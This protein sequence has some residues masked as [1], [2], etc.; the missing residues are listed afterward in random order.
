VSNFAFLEPEWPELHNE[1]VHAEQS[2]LADPR[3]SCFYA[4]RTLELTLD[5]LYQADDTLR[6]PYRNDL[7]GKITEPTLVALVGPKIRTKMDIIRRQ[8]NAAV[9]RSTP[10]STDGAVRVVGE[11]FQVMY[12]VARHYARDQANLPAASLAFDAAQ[13]PQP[14]STDVHLKNQAEI[15]TMAGQFARQQA[16]LAAARSKNRDLDAEIVALRAAIKAAKAMNAESAD[17]HDYNEAETRRL[18]IDLLLKEAGWTLEQSEDREFPVTGMPNPS[19]KGNVDYVLWD[20]NGRPLGLVEAKRTIKDARDGQHQAQLYAERLH[21]QFGQRP[22]IFY[23]NGYQTWI[24]DDLNY[25]PREVQGFYTQEELRLAIQRRTSRQALAGLLINDE[26]AGREYQGRAIRRIS[27]AFEQ[28]HRRAALLVMATGAGKTRTTIALVDLLVRANWVKRVLFLADRQALVTQATNAFKKHVPGIPTVNL[29][30]EKDTEARIFVSTYPTMM[31]LINETAD[32]Q[33]R[34]G[35]G[36]FDLVVI[37]E[38]HRSVYQKYR[39]IFEYFDALLLGLTATPKDEVDRNTYRLFNLRAGEPTDSYS[40]DDAVA[41]AWLVP[42]QAV[43][44]PLRFPR[45]GIKY[46]DLSDEEKAAWDELEWPEDDPPPTEVSADEVNKFLFN[47]DTIDK[48]LETLMTHGVRVEAGD[49]LGKTIIFARNNTHA[50][51]IAERFNEI[52][53]EHKGEFAQVIT[54]QKVYAQDLIDKFSIRDRDPHIAISV[55]MLD[56][57]IDVPEVVNLVFAKPIHSKT[58]FWQMIGRGTR[59][60]P[61]LFG[62]NLDKGGFRVFDL[63]QNIEYFNQELPPIE[64]RLQ[65]SLSEQIFR[66]RADLLLELDQQAA[67][68]GPAAHLPDES[69]QE[70]ELRRD[71]A[72]RLQ[73]EVAGMDPGN[74][75]VRR[76]LQ[77]VDTYREPGN[78]EHLTPQKHAEVTEHLAGLPTAFREDEHG[79]EAKRFDYL[80]LRLQLAYLNAATGYVGLRSQVQEVASALL[81]P[82]TL[83]IPAV[84][85]QQV[86]LEEVAGG[87]WWQDVTLPMLETMRK[88][89]RGLVKL[90]PRVRRGVVYTDFE[91]ELGELSLPELRGVPLGPN[92]T[93]FEARVR[94]YVRS[95]ANQS[96]VRK[97]WRNEQVTATD[98][99]ELATIFTEPG[100]GIHEDVEQ[101]TAEHGGFGLFLRSMTGLD[102]EAAF[103][104][105]GLFRSGRTFTPPQQG[106]LNLLIDVL[107]KNGLVTPRSL[108]GSPFTLRAPRGPE[109][110]FTANEVSAIVAVLDAVRA[111]AQPTDAA[112]G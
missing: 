76:H 93:R 72:A 66:R 3:A 12:W 57:G 102:Y 48:T 84:R 87:E 70:A 108:Y 105:F 80:A 92:K 79:E 21:E 69:G 67:S 17:T 85:Q 107:A 103:E 110:L 74:I 112:A 64:G 47:A 111:T 15:Q 68:S 50:E 34:F 8:G 13:L 82:F 42:P 27:E 30:T 49:R 36:Y 77:E 19:G 55:D 63:C 71:L 41:D 18:I 22:I 4:R 24:W 83:N 88:R 73:A 61:D 26:I 94:T 58:K 44:V 97:I 99:N 6:L 46:D 53:P 109:D 11:L 20:D 78:W 59:L 60:C 81:D 51:F 95:H 91:D 56:T 2:A 33:R 37:D 38:A 14:V 101:V 1:A 100:F 16:E 35:P 9:H 40:L 10:V 96:V 106:Y 54:Y 23:T 52:Y 89:L 28:Q 65:P 32:G 45:R 98:L 104:T 39:T 5:W 43:D 29:L 75:E 25:P 86:L 90:L 62:P 31:G 7:Y